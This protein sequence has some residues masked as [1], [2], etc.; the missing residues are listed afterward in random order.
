MAKITLNMGKFEDRVASDLPMS[1]CAVFADKIDLIRSR[2]RLL[3]G[4]DKALADMYFERGVSIRQMSKM[5][6]VS[7]TTI[8]RRVRKLKERLLGREYLICLRS[9]HLLDHN[10][11]KIASDRFVKGMS[12]KKIAEGNGI[13]V[14]KV[15][16][17]LT[18]IDDVVEQSK[19]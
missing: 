2:A 18:K 9:S 5:S 10:C 6:G 15:K 4:K 17:I 3:E 16:K 11:I 13:S 14:Y 1:S 7:E 19:S 12:I 8:S